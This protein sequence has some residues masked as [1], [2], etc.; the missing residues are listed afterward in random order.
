V[1]SLLLSELCRSRG[2]K[3]GRRMICS[4]CKEKIGKCQSHPCSG[5]L[6][7]KFYCFGGTHFCSIVCW[8]EW[9]LKGEEERLVEA[10]AIRR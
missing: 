3:E 10:E 8:K 7:G 6:E 1:V 2:N 9:F 4:V 5:K